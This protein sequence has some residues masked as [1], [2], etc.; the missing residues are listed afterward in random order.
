MQDRILQLMQL[1]QFKSNG[2][3]RTA[4]TNKLI[5]HDVLLDKISRNGYE[6]MGL[7]IQDK[8]QDSFTIKTQYPIPLA[9]YMYRY[10]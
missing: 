10:T 8:E 2:N 1:I 6:S 7:L 5:G 4:I 3:F 9:F